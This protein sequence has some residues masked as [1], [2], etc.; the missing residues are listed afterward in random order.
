M[1]VITTVPGSK[2]IEI[3]ERPEPQI[4]QPDEIKLKITKIGICGTD[5]EIAHGGRADAPPGTNELV[6]GHEM[7]G[8]VVAVG[9]NVT[10]VKPGDYA[11][12]TVRRDCGECAPC[13][14]GR[15]DMCQ[16]GKYTE[17]GIR[18]Y[19][20]YM[21]EYVVDKEKYCLRVP[22]DLVDLGV[23][24]E[25]M[26]VS[27]K[28]VDEALKIQAARIPGATYDG[29]LKGRTA[30][31]V[32][33]GPIGL[34]GAIA[35]RLRGA[36]VLGMDIVDENSPRPSVLKAIGGKYINGKEVK[37]DTIDELHGHIDLIFEAAGVAKLGF[38]IIDALGINGIYVMTGVPGADRPAD[39][40]A[41][42]IMQQMVL[43]NQVMIGSVN[44]SMEHNL[45]ALNDMAECKKKWP[46]VLESIIT[47]VM[48]Y[49]KINEALANTHSDEIKTIIEF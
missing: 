36:E 19:D 41:G 14:V 8:R 4:S 12:F 24:T 42:A 39:I 17:R 47:E 32:G 6:L 38:D 49:T 35:L 11:V 27:V 43:M 46:G 15:N 21:A 48:P 26:S 16:T 1:K 29:W 23:L 10:K 3:K 5:R 30:L 20:G 2:I 22:D 7:L 44:A 45:M 40:A 9:E 25:P 33:L 34:L 18:A 31:V 28:A 37:A 13:N